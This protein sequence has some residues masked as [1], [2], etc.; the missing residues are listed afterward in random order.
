MSKEFFGR[1][2][3]A[4]AIVISGYGKVCCSC[5]HMRG[6]MCDVCASAETGWLARERPASISYL[7]CVVNWQ[8]AQILGKNFVQNVEKNRLTNCLMCDKIFAAETHPIPLYHKG[9]VLSSAK[10]TK[11]RTI[12]R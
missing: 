11:K 9:R 2:L 10:S 5:K 7:V 1:G 6:H 12:R 8:I 3:L 4:R